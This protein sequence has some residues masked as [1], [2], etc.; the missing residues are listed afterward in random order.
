MCHGFLSDGAKESA[1][2]AQF[3][4]EKSDFLCMTHQ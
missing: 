3:N 1:V 2:V 4:P